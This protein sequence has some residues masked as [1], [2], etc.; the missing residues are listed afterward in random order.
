MKNFMMLVSLYVNRLTNKLMKLSMILGICLCI[1]MTIAALGQVFCR[2]TNLFTF[3]SSEEIARFCMCWLAMLGSAVALRQGRHLGVRVLVDRLPA[4]IYD[5]YLAPIIQ[6]V[7]LS[8]FIMLTIKGW[9]FAMRG[10]GQLS[11]SLEIP[12]MYPYLC[13]PVGGML[14]ALNVFS[15]MLQDHFPTAEGS[16]ASIAT[17]VMENLTE[18]T[19]EFEQK[20]EVFDPLNSPKTDI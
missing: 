12:M 20:S 14:M 9:T 2:F 5:K 16:N 19:A 7:M 17:A 15:D 10:A 1:I 6:L 3:H 11:P 13:L 18:V 4:G 8:F